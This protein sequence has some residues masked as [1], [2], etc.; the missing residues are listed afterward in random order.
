MWDGNKSER[1][2]EPF[3]MGEKKKRQVTRHMS[4]GEKCQLKE[5]K[6]NSKNHYLL[7]SLLLD[8]YNEFGQSQ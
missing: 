7:Y 1:T 2:E 5:V 8:V 4:K 6:S 3:L